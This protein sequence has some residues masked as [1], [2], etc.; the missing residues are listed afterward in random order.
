MR[1]VS[2]SI[3]MKREMTK[4]KPTKARK[5]LPRQAPATKKTKKRV[6]DEEEEEYDLLDEE[7]EEMDE[8]EDAN[9]EGLE[10]EK[11]E[12]GPAE[13]N[14]YLKIQTRRKF[15]EGILNEPYFE[16]AIEGT[17][18]R[19]VVGEMD[20]VAVYRMCEVVSVEDGTRKYQLPDTKQTTIL[21]MTVAIGPKTKSRIKFTDVSNRR[22][23]ADE[24]SAY[25][26]ALSESR[27]TTYSESGAEDQEQT[28]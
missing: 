13:L 6:R 23:T 24:L 14:D 25:L 3:A 21:R 8:E 4:K 20:G 18:V 26:D 7:G 27:K 15:I 12:S 16:S 1:T 10:E 9:D 22:I 19:I 17:F 2:Y 5:P 11:D 28:R